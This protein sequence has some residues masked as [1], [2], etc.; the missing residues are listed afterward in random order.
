MIISTTQLVTFSP[1]GTSRKIGQ[2]FAAELSGG[3]Y[4]LL[5]LTY[6]PQRCN[7]S[8]DSLAVIVVPVYSGRV[9]PHARRRLEAVR[10]NKTPAVIIVVYGNRAF[11]DALIELRNICIDS[12][13]IPLA[14]AAFIGQHSYSTVDKPIAAGRPDEDDFRL[15]REFA[16]QVLDVVKNYMGEAKVLDVPGNEEYR[17]GVHSVPFMPLVDEEKCVLC[18]ECVGSCPIK[19]ISITGEHVVITGQCT[20]CCA[21]IHKCPE[22]AL[23]LAAPRVKEVADM[24]YKTCQERKEPQF[25]T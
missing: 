19:V 15:V 25:F 3:D 8:S 1:T 13:F 16:V 6:D 7:I 18:G 22:G 10:A 24:L 21:C 9:A 4:Q 23:S 11:D 2:L 17:P 20:L 14:G 5:D 12:G